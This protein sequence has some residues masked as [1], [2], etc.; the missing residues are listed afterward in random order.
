MRQYYMVRNVAF[1]NLFGVFY[2][3]LTFNKPSHKL[4]VLFCPLNITL[5]THRRQAAP[6]SVCLRNVCVCAWVRVH[7]HI[8]NRSNILMSLASFLY[9]RHCSHFIIYTSYIINMKNCVFLF[10]PCAAFCGPD[11]IP[12]LFVSLLAFRYSVSSMLCRIGASAYV[13]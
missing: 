10:A 2:V 3:F 12:A 4:P 7:V 6:W 1:C 9:R 13:L 5:G 11:L 8:H